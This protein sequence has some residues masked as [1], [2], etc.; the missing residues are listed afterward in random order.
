[1]P[2]AGKVLWMHKRKAI[3]AGELSLLADR[4]G[5]EH[6]GC[7]QTPLVRLPQNLDSCAAR[8]SVIRRNDVCSPLS[9][10]ATNSSRS[11]T[12]TVSA[13][14]S[15]FA[16]RAL[17]NS[18]KSGSSSR[19]K[20]RKDLSIS[21]QFQ[22]QVVLG[23]APPGSPPVA[24]SMICSWSSLNWGSSHTS[25]RFARTMTRSLIAINSGSSE[26]TKM[27]PTPAPARRRII[28]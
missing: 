8:Q 3:L 1:M 23:T 28:L 26:D 10:A 19:C 24:A 7:A 15:S 14:S 16:S 18:Q 22:A 6:E 20:M 27:M 13:A 11:L 4:P 2:G 21:A 12:R 25:L 9:K 17:T 5:N